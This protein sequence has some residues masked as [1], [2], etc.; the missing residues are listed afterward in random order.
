MSTVRIH[1]DHAKYTRGADRAVLDAAYAASVE[2]LVEDTYRRFD[3]LRQT[4][5]IQVLLPTALNEDR[6]AS[7]ITGKWGLTMGWQCG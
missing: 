1:P 6:R 2:F 5:E 3:G 4:L 7:L